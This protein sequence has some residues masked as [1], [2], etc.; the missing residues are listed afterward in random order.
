MEAMKAIFYGS[1]DTEVAKLVL[2]H[3]GH[4]FLSSKGQGSLGLSASSSGVS[5]LMSRGDSIPVALF[6]Y[7]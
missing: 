2:A 5:S 7:L 6:M 4:R 3:E 1:M